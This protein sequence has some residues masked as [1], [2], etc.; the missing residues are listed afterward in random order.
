MAESSYADLPEGKQGVEDEMV[1]VEYGSS[2]QTLSSSSLNPPE[3]GAP[4]GQRYD[5]PP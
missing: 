1:G 3:T 2:E 4:R 5:T